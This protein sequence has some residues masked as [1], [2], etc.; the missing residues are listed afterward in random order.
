M[1]YPMM[2]RSDEYF[3][4]KTTFPDDVVVVVK[5]DEIMNAGY[6]QKYFDRNTHEGQTQKERDGG[7]RGIP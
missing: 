6:G 4:Q 7:E 5:L 3:L 2:R 1:M